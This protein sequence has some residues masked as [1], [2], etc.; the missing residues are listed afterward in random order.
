MQLLSP[1]SPALVGTGRRA[2]L[3][4]KPLAV[5]FASSENST[6]TGKREFYP[7]GADEETEALQGWLPQVTCQAQLQEHRVVLW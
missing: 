5:S 6:D 7:H 1:R 3:S 2:N 4:K